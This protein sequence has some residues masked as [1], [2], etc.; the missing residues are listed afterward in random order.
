MPIPVC[1]LHPLLTLPAD[2]RFLVV[3]D[4]SNAQIVVGQADRVRKMQIDALKIMIDP[5]S[6]MIEFPGFKQCL[7]R[8]AG[9]DLNFYYKDCTLNFSPYTAKSGGE[10]MGTW[11]LNNLF[12]SLND[13][14]WQ[15]RSWATVLDKETGQFVSSWKDGLGF[16]ICSFIPTQVFKRSTK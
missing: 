14:K 16:K 9:C 2:P 1:S 15:A 10:S 13:P 11:L 7:V 6:S 3:P 5:V 8:T 4:V 12:W